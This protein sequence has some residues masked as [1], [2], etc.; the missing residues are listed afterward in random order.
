MAKRIGLQQTYN[1]SLGTGHIWK[2]EEVFTCS[3]MARVREGWSLGEHKS[4]VHLIPVGNL[5]KSSPWF[6]GCWLWLPWS[7]G[8]EP[9]DWRLQFTSRCHSLYFKAICVFFKVIKAKSNWRRK[10]TSQKVWRIAG[11]SKYGSLL[12]C[13]TFKSLFKRFSD[14]KME[15]FY[16]LL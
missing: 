6:R 12:N 10:R 4:S 14:F 7:W 5:T 1:P 8:S 9:M 3:R 15:V 2:K 11:R 16:N 13:S